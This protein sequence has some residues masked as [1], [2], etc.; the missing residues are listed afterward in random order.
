MHFLNACPLLPQ[1][2]H[3][4]KWL[5]G[6]PLHEETD[7]SAVL[8]SGSAP[9]TLPSVLEPTAYKN[10]WPDEETGVIQIWGKD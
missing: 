7:P 5:R 8:S 2:A 10:R 3:F 1:T 4:P 6:A 9:E